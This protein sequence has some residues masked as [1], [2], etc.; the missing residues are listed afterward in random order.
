V[1]PLRRPEVRFST[2]EGLVSNRISSIVLASSSAKL[3]H[4][5]RISGTA[6]LELCL[7]L[8]GVLFLLSTIMQKEHVNVSNLSCISQHTIERRWSKQVAW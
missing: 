3:D 7:L 4:F 2:E 1:F 5:T 8:L 6:T